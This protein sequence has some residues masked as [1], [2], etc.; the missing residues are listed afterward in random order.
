MKVDTTQCSLVSIFSKK[1]TN[2]RSPDRRSDANLS[3]GLYLPLERRPIRNEPVL[4]RLH[5]GKRGVD[6]VDD[7]AY[8]DR[9]F[10]RMHET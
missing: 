2:E 1:H 3:R 5:R 8:L 6:V 10:E 4:S 9:H 7:K